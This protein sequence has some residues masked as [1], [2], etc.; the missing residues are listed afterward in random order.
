MSLLIGWCVD[1]V[2]Y[3]A[4]VIFQLTRGSS[5]ALRRE[6]YRRDDSAFTISLFAVVAAAESCGAVAMLLLGRDEQDI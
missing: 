1:V 2:T 4:L 3:V 6:A 5:E